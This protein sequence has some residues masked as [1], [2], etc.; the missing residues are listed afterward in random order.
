MSNFFFP[1]VSISISVIIGHLLLTVLARRH[2][3]PS[4]EHDTQELMLSI[5]KNFYGNG[6]AFF[7]TFLDWI[8]SMDCLQ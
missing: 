5:K 1:I 4:E 6:N 3:C 8:F 2:P 7:P